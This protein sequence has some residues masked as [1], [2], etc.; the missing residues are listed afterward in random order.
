MA[1]KNANGPVLVTLVFNL[2][3]SGQARLS[4]HGNG[5]ILQK[6]QTGGWR[7]WAIVPLWGLG[8]VVDWLKKRGWREEA[9]P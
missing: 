9:Q 4:V 2:K 6:R 3:T 8:S 7:Q 5:H 1:R